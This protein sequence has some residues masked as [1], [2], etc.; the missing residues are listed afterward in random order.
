MSS[1]GAVRLELTWQFVFHPAKTL[2]SDLYGLWRA[3]PVHLP[4]TPLRTTVVPVR[5]SQVTKKRL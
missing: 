3:V 5:Q 1:P 4:A 2:E